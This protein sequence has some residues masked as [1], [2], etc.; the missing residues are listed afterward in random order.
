MAKYADDMAELHKQPWIIREGLDSDG[1]EWEDVVEDPD[2][3][4]DLDLNIE[5]DYDTSNQQSDLPGQ[6]MTRIDLRKPL[7]KMCDGINPQR[8]V[9]DYPT[10]LKSFPTGLKIANMIETQLTETRINMK[11][12]KFRQRNGLP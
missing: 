11:G 4:P 5:S 9:W 1:D 2:E 12:V 10:T 7:W 8:R 6:T 3:D